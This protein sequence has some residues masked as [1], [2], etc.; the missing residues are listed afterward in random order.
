MFIEADL[1]FFSRTPGHPEVH[2]TPGVEVT[3]GPLGQGFANA[4]GMAIAQEHL[5]TRFNRQEFP[6]VDNKIYVFCG[7]GC[8][9]EGVT[10]E[11]ASL[12]GHLGLGNLIVIFDDNRVTIDGS[13]NISFSDNV[14]MRFQAYGWNVQTVEKGEFVGLKIYKV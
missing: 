13:T 7:D 1:Y 10:S 14:E 5:K 4:V 12:A 11:A 9:M 3:T 2:V 8:M 6:I